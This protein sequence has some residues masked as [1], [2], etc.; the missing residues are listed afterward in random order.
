MKKLV[1]A[2]LIACTPT[3]LVG[4]EIIVRI[5]AG[6]GYIKITGDNIKVTSV[7]VVD[8]DDDDGTT[9]PPPVTDKFGLTAFCKKEADKVNDAETRSGIGAIY[10]LLADRIR[11]GDITNPQAAAT[12]AK[13]AVDLFLTQTD[14]KDE[15]KGF[16]SAL[17]SR[18]D[19][20]AKEKKIRTIKDVGQAYAEIAAGMKSDQKALSP[21]LLELIIK[22]IEIVLQLIGR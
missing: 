4:E 6:V 5:P 8:L 14:K 16:Q 11:T 18:L 9:T 22:I 12:A 1:I 3:T 2:L 10:R 13:T 17:K 15:W 19:T 7:K 21:E 20:L